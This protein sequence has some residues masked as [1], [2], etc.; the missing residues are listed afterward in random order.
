VNGTAKRTTF[1]RERHWHALRVERGKMQRTGQSRPK[2]C[3]P[4]RSVTSSLGKGYLSPNYIRPLVSDSRSIVC[5]PARRH[6]QGMTS[7]TSKYRELTAALEDFLFKLQYDTNLRTSR[8]RNE[9]FSALVRGSINIQRAMTR[10]A[11]LL[12]EPRSKK[13]SNPVAFRSRFHPTLSPV[14]KRRSSATRLPYGG[15]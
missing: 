14:I 15:N 5:S 8:A 4:E 7:K 2:H 1:H 3:L 12:I 13:A 10:S 9:L 11:G 6:T